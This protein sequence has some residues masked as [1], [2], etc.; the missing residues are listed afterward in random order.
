MDYGSAAELGPVAAKRALQ[1]H[2]R[3]RIN[4]GGVLLSLFVPWLIF[5]AV[6]AVLTFSLRASRPGLAVLILG[7]AAAVILGA[8]ALAYTSLRARS[9]AAFAADGAALREPHWYVFVAA[10]SLLALGLAVGV[11]EYSWNAGGMGGLYNMG[12]LN[13]YNHVDPARMRGQQLMDAGVVQ[14]V[15]GTF[16]DLKLSMGFR[17][18]DVY[19]VAPITSVTTPLQSYD[20]WAV[21]KNCCSGMAADFQCGQYQNSQARAGL[22]LMDDADRP[23]FRLAVQQAQATHGIRSEHPLF[24]WWVQD[25]ASEYA[26][27]YMQGWRTYFGSMV[28][29]FIM[30]LVL[31][32][33][34]VGTFASGGCGALL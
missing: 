24:F 29:H 21:G 11:G 14:F 22:R 6:S 1:P 18:T 4:I 31:V 27:M 30:Q 5:C 32:S 20:F 13:D 25:P 7:G 9:D 23:F 33:C 19:C 17:N 26:G 2:R 8:S 10:T 12:N 34:A 15:E 3:R 16:L 28:G